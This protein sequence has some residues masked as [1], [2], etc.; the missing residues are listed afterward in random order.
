MQIISRIYDKLPESLQNCIDEIYYRIPNRIKF[1]KEYD[2]FSAF[3]VEFE[4]YSKKEKERYLVNKLKTLLVYAYNNTVYYKKLFDEINFNPYSFCDLK[5]MI[6]IPLL[7]KSDIMNR[8][9]DFVSFKFRYRNWKVRRLTTGGT[10]GEQMVFYEQRHFSEARE[11][12]Y[13]DYLFAKAGYK[14]GMLMAVLRND[15]LQPNVLWKMDFRTHKL[16]FDPFHLT[17]ENIK[18]IIDKCNHEKIYF[19]HTYPST[20]LAVCRYICKTGY[21]LNYAPKAIFA[22]SE[23]LYEGQREVIEKT[24]KCKLYIH[25]GHSEKGA[26]AGWRIDSEKYYIEDAYGYCELVYDNQKDEYGQIV[27]TGFNNYVMPLIRYATG[28]YVKESREMDDICTGTR[29]FCEV[30][31]RWRQE[32]LFRI[33]GT[34]I[35]L[36]AVNTHSDI[37]KN[38]LKYQ[39]Y[40]EEKGICYI[41]ILAG[42]KYSYKD[43]E[44]ILNE[45]QKKMGEGLLLKA[46]YVKDIESS[47]SGKYK[48]LI[49]MI[50]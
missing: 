12:A 20:I 1:G 17:E 19:F 36:T 34:Q 33:D 32:M 41:N 8:T 43:E 46:R 44:N 4:N 28:D 9:D 11:V 18:K 6:Q 13:F 16:V 26:V 25:Y 24:M 48:Y 50:S 22:S 23:N 3:L 35:S 29:C 27:T 42:E 2:V 5:Q 15:V 45:L 49:Q 39:F 10:S 40:Q 38:V 47:K 7:N 30:H 31:G 14:R 21:G 37:F